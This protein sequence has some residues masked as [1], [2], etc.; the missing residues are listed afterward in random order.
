MDLRRR[1]LLAGLAAVA[2]LPAAGCA[3][4]VA[5]AAAPLDLADLEAR[6]GADLRLFARSGA[7]AADWRGDKRALYASTFKLFLAGAHLERAQQ[8]PGWLDRTVA[9]TAADLVFHAPVTGELVGQAVT[10]ERL[11]QATV[12]TSDNPAANILMRELGGLEA[13]AGWYRSIGD[14]V[15]RVDRWETALNGPDGDKDTTTARQA[16]A[17]IETLLLGPS[18]RLEAAQRARLEDWLVGS[19]NPD[20]I[21]AGAPEGWVVAHKSGTSG[22]GHVNDIGLLRPPSGPP[23]T[24]AVYFSGPEDLPTEQADLVVAEA[25]RRALAALGHG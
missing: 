21:Q 17:D 14:T 22:S 15:T 11:C 6:H 10:L 5:D 2:A 9:V 25:T 16:V 12:E 24:L 20:R 8:S 1:H 13:F 3:M 18:P 19:A 23:V 4:G 7:R